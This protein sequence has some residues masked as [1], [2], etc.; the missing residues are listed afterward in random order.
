MEEEGDRGEGERGRRVG[1]MEAEGGDGFG[2]GSRGQKGENEEMEA[3]VEILPEVGEGGRGG[4]W[5]GRREM[6]AKWDDEG[7]GRRS[8]SRGEMLAEDGDVG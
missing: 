4:T 2:R 6:V 8:W 5:R 3:E 1:E 7:G